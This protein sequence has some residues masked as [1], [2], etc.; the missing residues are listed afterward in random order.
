MPATG[1]KAAGVLSETGPPEHPA[2]ASPPGAEA[3]HGVPGRGAWF[4]EP[5]PPATQLWGHHK[6]VCVP[7]SPLSGRT[8]LRHHPE[9]MTV[10]SP[11]TGGRPWPLSYRPLRGRGLSA[12]KTTWT[13][14][15]LRGLAARGQRES[16]LRE[17]HCP[18]S[19]APQQIPRVRGACETLSEAQ[20]TPLPP[21]SLCAGRHEEEPGVGA[22]QP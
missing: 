19:R 8:D 3:Q 14:L 20:N 9:V 6:V 22:H 7:D 18:S 1:P 13:G 10:S 5:D 21:G 17:G 15:M 16:S 4:R 2:T 12:G 11:Q